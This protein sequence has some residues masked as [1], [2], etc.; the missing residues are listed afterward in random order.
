M[1]RRRDRED[2]EPMNIYTNRIPEERFC[3]NGVDL[4]DLMLLLRTEA[5]LANNILPEEVTAADFLPESAASCEET[6]VTLTSGPFYAP[7]DGELTIS[8]LNPRAR[9][10]LAQVRVYELKAQGKIP[11]LKRA[12]WTPGEGC[13]TV[14]LEIPCA[15]AHALE[16][17]VSS[18]FYPSAQMLRGETAIPVLLA[19][20]FI[21]ASGR[22]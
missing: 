10:R 14:T 4:R 20:D 6:T 15:T 22:F 16:I 12:V 2:F 17:R 19:H 8:V 9:A 3:G 1:S 21:Q 18:G 7:T 5:R 13:A 11:L